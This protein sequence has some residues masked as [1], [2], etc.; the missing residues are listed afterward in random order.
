MV[1]QSESDI[2]IQIKRNLNLFSEI[3]FLSIDAVR[4]KSKHKI[5]FGPEQR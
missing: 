3:A 1:V 2:V 4:I 5:R